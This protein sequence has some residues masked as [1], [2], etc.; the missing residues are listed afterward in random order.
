[1]SE[2]TSNM[3]FCGMGVNHVLEQGI[4][5]LKVMGEITEITQNDKAL[6]RYL[7]TAAEITGGIKDFQNRSAE[8]AL[9]VDEAPQKMCS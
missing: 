2:F 5:S 6:T 9:P 1:M 8:R 7:L 4:R 3:P